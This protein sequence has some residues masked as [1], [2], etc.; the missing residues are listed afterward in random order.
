MV[1][2]LAHI[3]NPVNVGPQSDLYVAQPLTFESMRRARAFAEGDVKVALFSCHY[4]EDAEIVPRD[5]ETT[6]FLERS[7]QDVGTFERPRKL[8]LLADILQRLYDASEADYLIY[9][10][11]DIAVVPHFYAAVARLIERGFDAFVINRRTVTDRYTDLADL[12]LMYAEVGD[13]H[14]GFDC[15]VFSRAVFPRLDLGEVCIGAAW[16]GRVLVWNLCMLATRFHEFGD[17][18]LTF[19]LGNSNLWKDPEYVA[20]EQHNRTQAA[21]VL[22]RLVPIDAPI[23]DGAPIRAYLKPDPHYVPRQPARPPKA[24]RLLARLLGRQ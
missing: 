18:H 5:F 20:Y 1:V 6:A 10:N 22:D 4:P 21:A 12:P 24:A 15:F 13:P 11:A 3:V 19:H 9:T 2:S 16:V 14:P 17:L 7:V 23:D 8:P